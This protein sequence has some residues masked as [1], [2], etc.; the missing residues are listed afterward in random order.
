MKSVMTE[1]HFSEF[2]TFTV[3]CN[4]ALAERDLLGDVKPVYLVLALVDDLYR[5]GTPQCRWR[6][7]YLGHE[8]RLHDIFCAQVIADR[9]SGLASGPGIRAFEHASELM[10]ALLAK[11]VPCSVDELSCM[12]IHHV[13]FDLAMCE[14]VGAPL[15][16]YLVCPETSKGFPALRVI[17]IDEMM[18]IEALA[19][20]ALQ[21]QQF[22][23]AR[24]RRHIRL[25]LPRVLHCES[26]T[27]ITPDIE[28][29]YLHGH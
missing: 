8:D 3:P 20:T 5:G 19:N 16:D 24:V 12:G 2:A 25:C 4:P 26:F 23:G 14:L 17:P 9:E 1:S 7:V 27:T 10:A 15:G 6:V 11:V 13:G 22:L 18:D 21:M 28:Q 29:G